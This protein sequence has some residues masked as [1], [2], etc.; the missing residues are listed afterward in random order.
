[1]VY[2]TKFAKME[3]CYG[4]QRI[5]FIISC[6]TVTNKNDRGRINCICCW[7]LSHLLS[8]WPF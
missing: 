2:V 7:K 3:H 5:R 8:Y 6:F 1:M 4:T